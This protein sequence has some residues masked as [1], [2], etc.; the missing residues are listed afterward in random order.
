MSHVRNLLHA[1]SREGVETSHSPVV[2]RPQP[3]RA[4]LRDQPSPEF[5]VEEARI[6]PEC[7]I[8]YH[9]DPRSPAADRFR[10]LRMRLRDAASAGIL[11]K[12]LVTSPVAGDGKSTAILNLATALSERGKRKVLVIEADLHRSSLSEILQ[13]RPWRGL[14]ECLTDDSESPLSAIRLIEPLGWWLMP[15]GEPRGNPT[16]LLQTPA[17]AFVLERVSACFDWVLIDSPP[18]LASTDAISLHQH[19]D[20][21]LLVARAGRTSRESIEQSVTLLGTQKIAG[22]LLNAVEHGELRRL[23]ADYASGRRLQ[24]E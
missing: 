1:P 21:T 14:T 4:P 2:A 17:L 24:D 6:R 18:V 16:E 15:A 7:R 8:V 13:L 5:P 3:V 22:V 12:L 19:A 23:Q 9:T 11:K 20:G 10:F